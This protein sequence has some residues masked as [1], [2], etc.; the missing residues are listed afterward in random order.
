MTRLGLPS[1]AVA[2]IAAAALAGCVPGRG[3]S[4]ADA[5]VAPAESDAEGVERCSPAVEALVGSIA[6][7]LDSGVAISNAWTVRSREFDSVYFT[8]ARV[9]R[10]GG[11]GETATW[12]T[13]AP[14][15][16]QFLFAVTELARESGDFPADESFDGGS[17]GV[18]E[19]QRCARVR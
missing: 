4:P 17:D 14:E 6:G 13:L 1:L 18:R 9:D 2:A 11:A 7:G 19:S 15:G 3:E 10:E 12:A 16:G 5:P 8:S